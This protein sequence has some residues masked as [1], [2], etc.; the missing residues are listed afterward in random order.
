MEPGLPALLDGRWAE[1]ASGRELVAVF[2]LLAQW[3][4][5]LKESDLLFEEKKKKKKQHSKQ[6]LFQRMYPRITFRWP[7]HSERLILPVMGLTFLWVW[8]HHTP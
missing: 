2:T 7:S 6:T 3:L 8:V 5:S 4:E 1:A